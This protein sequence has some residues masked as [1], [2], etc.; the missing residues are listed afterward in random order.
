MTHSATVVIS[1]DGPGG[2]TLDVRGDL[3]LLRELVETLQPLRAG[4]KHP[5]GDPA[6]PKPK[7]ESTDDRTS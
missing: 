5:V 4:K 3:D 6:Q 1:L 2:K 7:Q